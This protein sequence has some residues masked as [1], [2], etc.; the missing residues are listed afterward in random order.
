M[1]KTVDVSWTFLDGDV[2][3]VLEFDLRDTNPPGLWVLQFLDGWASS[4]PD[5]QGYVVLRTRGEDHPRTLTAWVSN[6]AAMRGFVAGEAEKTWPERFTSVVLV[7]RT[8]EYKHPDCHT[9]QC[10]P[11]WKTTR[12]G[13]CE[14]VI[15]HPACPYCRCLRV[16]PESVQ[17]ALQQSEPLQRDR[18]APVWYTDTSVGSA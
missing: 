12:S 13:G 15:H 10:L 17:R 3:A 4:H 9:C 16:T 18:V 5:V 11:R 14:H 8:R 1:D 2:A 7:Q 6:G